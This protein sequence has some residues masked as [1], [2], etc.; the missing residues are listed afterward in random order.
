MIIF[1]KQL[2]Q[3][4]PAY[5]G[6]YTITPADEGH[7]HK[8]YTVEFRTPSLNVHASSKP[9]IDII[10]GGFKKIL[11]DLWDIFIDVLGLTV[12]AP[13]VIGKQ[14][15][16]AYKDTG[17]DVIDKAIDI[18]KT[19]YI[20]ATATEIDSKHETFKIPITELDVLCTNGYWAK[21]DIHG[22]FE[23]QDDRGEVAECKARL[24]W[25]GSPPAD[26]EYSIRD[27]KRHQAADVI[28]S[29]TGLSG[30]PGYAVVEL[31]LDLTA[32]SD[33][34]V[35]ATTPPVSK[36]EVDKVVFEFVHTC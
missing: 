33:G 11:D 8:R 25:N 10:G 6:S 32:E 30:A 9:R 26:A 24:S 15:M 21:A 5:V 2:E 20:I 7:V 17:K 19:V 1:H 12:G 34:D 31:S 29:L 27:A 18:G 16:Q 28:P 22:D 13:Y 35:K 3:L 36:V 23:T 14:G 4:N